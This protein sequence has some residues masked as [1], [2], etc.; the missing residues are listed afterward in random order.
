MIRYVIGLGIAAAVA[1]SPPSQAGEP[2]Y[3]PF[4]TLKAAQNVSREGLASWYGDDFQGNETASGEP[5]NMNALTAAHRDLPLGTRI[6]VTNLSND[7]S[8]ILKVNDR[9][10]YIPGRSLDV[11]RAAARLLGFAQQG[12]THVRIQVLR[13]PH[14]SRYHLVCPGARFFSM[15]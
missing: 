9:G 7:R 8:L 15:N 3:L 10:P 13:L 4:C 11:S 12:L 6:R 5:F 14:N 1:V 2:C